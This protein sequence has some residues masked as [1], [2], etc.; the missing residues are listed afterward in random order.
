MRST[1][2]CICV[3]RFLF[4]GGRETRGSVSVVSVVGGVPFLSVFGWLLQVY[5]VI[6]NGLTGGIGVHGLVGNL[7]VFD[8]FSAGLLVCYL[9]RDDFLFLCTKV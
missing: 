5:R 6:G 7:C 8:G 1:L 9:R 4:C 3:E 2:L